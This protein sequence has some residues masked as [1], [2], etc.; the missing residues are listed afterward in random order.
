MLPIQE[1]SGVEGLIVE[2]G[3]PFLNG[4]ICI[5]LWG[6][7]GLMQGQ[8]QGLWLLSGPWLSPH[9]FWPRVFWQRGTVASKTDGGGVSDSESS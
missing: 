5:D 2:N 3:A 4:A 8:L 6:P 1:V 7:K 9:G